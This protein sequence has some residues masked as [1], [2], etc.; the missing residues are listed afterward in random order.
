V[1]NVGGEKHAG[2]VGGVGLETGDRN[3][4]GNVAVLNHS[5]DIDVARVISSA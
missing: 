3:K 2:D 5:P 4:G 1:A